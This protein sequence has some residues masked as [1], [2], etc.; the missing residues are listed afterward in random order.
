M[1]IL[2]DL[3]G[4]LTDTSDIRFKPYKDGKQVIQ[5]ADIPFFPGAKNFLRNVTGNGHKAI[6]ISDSHPQYVNQIATIL[7]LPAVC[8]TDKPNPQKTLAYIESVETI[9]PLLRD[10]DNFLI[11]GDT[12]LDIELGRRMNIR[13]VLTQLYQASNIEERDGIGQSWKPLKTGPTFYAKSYEELEEIIKNPNAH[14]LA[15]E[16][17]FQGVHSNKMVK[18]K[19]QNS[20]RGFTAFRCLAR[21]E[22]GEC[23]RFS[24]ADKYFQIDNPYR[25]QDFL[26]QLATGINNYLSRVSKFQEYKWDYL[27]YVSDKKTT[28]P[29]NK[30]KEIF[31]LVESP[32]KKVKLFEWSEKV[33][34]SLRNRPDYKSRREFISKYLFTKEGIDLNEK[35]IIIIDD[36]F[37]SSA[38][39]YEISSQLREKGAKNILFVA[40]FYLILPIESKNCSNMVDGLLCGKPM[41]IKI[42]KKDGH[43][44]YSCTPPKYGGQ[45]C[46]NI[47]N[48]PA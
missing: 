45:G 27:T 2:I 24:R 39:A 23:D 42:R 11:I 40:L 48:I 19:Y 12:W 46:G 3:D 37:T 13:T 33:E 4:T 22:D 28:T 25:S 10:Q 14:L 16:A 20:S 47:E 21:Q 30:M 6:I 7:D 5:S 43:K 41:K 32:F 31:D 35:S 26:S 1:V 44:F 38:T 15:L 36:Q 34:G 8:L 17:V 9:K 29:P 18:F